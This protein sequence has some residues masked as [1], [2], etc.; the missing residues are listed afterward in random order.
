MADNINS[1]SL[2]TRCRDL[3]AIDYRTLAFFRIT[4]AVLIL[5][6]LAARA[7]YLEA[8]Y[9]DAGVFPTRVLRSWDLY[10]S[11][12]FISDSYAFHATLFLVEGCAAVMLLVGWHTRIATVLSWFL[13]C[14]LHARNEFVNNGGDDLFRALLLWS[15]FLPL[16]R[17]WSLDAWRNRDETTEDE[18]T[19][20]EATENGSVLSVATVAILL[21]F[22]YLYLTTGLGKSG[23]DWHVDGTAIQLA[24][25]QEF[26]VQPFGRWLSQYP[27]FLRILTPTVFYF[28]VIAPLLLFVPF[29]R[30]SIRMWIILSFWLFQ[31]GL[32]LSLNTIL[33]PWVATAATLPFI[34]AS[35]WDWIS[36]RFS[37][38]TGQGTATDALADASPIDESAATANCEPARPT[39]W[40]WR[41]QQFAVLLIIGCVTA[42]SFN[43]YRTKQQA[44][45][46]KQGHSLGLINS[47]HMYTNVTTHSMIFKHDALLKNRTRLDLLQVDR[48][49]AWVPVQQIH[50]S[51]RF[52]LYLRAMTHKPRYSRYYMRWLIRSWNKGHGPTERILNLMR[53]FES[54][55][56]LP[57]GPPQVVRIDEARTKDGQTKY[58]RI[59]KPWV[60]DGQRS[61]QQ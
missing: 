33:F 6:D 24:L 48:D 23:P 35:F 9:T 37:R 55:R 50:H 54:K 46:C 13:L 7:F 32:R 53:S 15:M 5:C 39:T 22:V 36:T 40:A 26:M 27:D 11:L 10:L 30:T 45:I 52:E 17:R 3:F 21:Q 2:A 28:E 1:K 59:W 43:F 12:R 51:G 19:E 61:R 57:P 4:L 34:P 8:N 38:R 18:T 60:A 44:K 47:W 56:I 49:A 16:G 42:A 29:R 20:D 14:S 31:I 58:Y 41:L 25:G